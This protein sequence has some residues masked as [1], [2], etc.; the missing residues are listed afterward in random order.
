VTTSI[1]II[2]M[3]DA[4]FASGSRGVVAFSN[5][6]PRSYPATICLDR[7][8]WREARARRTILAEPSV[9]RAK[10]AAPGGAARLRYWAPYNHSCP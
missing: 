6:E 1:L 3:M 8:V 9:E 7:A 5:I 4:F 10:R 2:F